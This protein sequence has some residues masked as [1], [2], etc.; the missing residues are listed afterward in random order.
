MRTLEPA[1]FNTRLGKQI[2]RLYLG[3]QSVMR[4]I[5]HFLPRGI[6]L[7]HVNVSAAIVAR[8]RLKLS[9]FFQRD[10]LRR[11]VVFGERRVYKKQNHGLAVVNKNAKKF[12]AADLFPQR[13][14]IHQCRRR[15]RNDAKT[16][17]IAAKRKRYAATI[18]HA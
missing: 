7:A 9:S 4:G 6:L 17:V 16:E 3:R 18:R 1:S 15:F 8:S 13:I 11:C 12:F 2:A 14:V 10:F 5:E